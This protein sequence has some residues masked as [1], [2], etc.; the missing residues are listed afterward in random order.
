MYMAI[1]KR[2]PFHMF[3]GELDNMFAEMENR[4]QSLLP[5]Y[6]AYSQ[7]GRELSPVF[8]GGFTVDVKQQ[9]DQ[10][11]AKADLPGCNKEDVKIRLVRPNL[12]QISCQRTDEKEQEDKDF[13]IRE[14]FYGSVSR[15]VPL[16]VEVLEE[17]AQA[18]FEN[19]VLEVIFKRAEKESGGDIPIQ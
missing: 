11:I 4:F 14:R 12:L 6:P 2:D 18:K 16:P 5:S 19:G 1:I 13:F 17:G 8:S 10:V 15:S 9:D 7:G 3:R